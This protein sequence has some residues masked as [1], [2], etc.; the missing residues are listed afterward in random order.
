MQLLIVHRDVEIGVELVR[1]VR[2]YTRHECDLAGSEAAAVDWA[3]RHAQC[4]LLLTQLVAEGIDGLTL[5]GTL[6]QIFS[7]LQILFFPAYGA[8]ERR[9]E[10]AE[11]KV[12]PEPIDGDALLGTI[13][14]AEKTASLPQDSFHIVDLVQM[15]CLGRRSGAL[16]I[17]KGKRSGLLFFRDGR[18]LHAET[19][20]ARGPDA[21]FEMVEWKYVEFAY[22]PSIR[23]P[24]ETIA[25]PWDEALIEAVTLTNNRIR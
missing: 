14:R 12:F 1:M 3:H 17:V 10:I 2:D 15:C 6:S 23:A 18:L 5:G 11:T 7:G 9:L 8:S 19:T 22:N 13:E 20:A 25:Q 16:Q 4:R 24:A 21:L